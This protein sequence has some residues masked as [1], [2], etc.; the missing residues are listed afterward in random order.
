MFHPFGRSR[1][2]RLKPI[3]G[4]TTVVRVTEDRVRTRTTRAKNDAEKREDRKAVVRESIGKHRLP[5][6]KDITSGGGS[7]RGFY[8]RS[9]C[10]C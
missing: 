7:Q 9:P 1:S 10:C 4:A 2:Y 8:L 3:D 5:T 6:A